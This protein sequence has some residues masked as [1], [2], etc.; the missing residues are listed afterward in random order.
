MMEK[1]DLR[2][3]AEAHRK[4]LVVPGHAAVL[5]EYAEALALTPGVVVA[6]YAAFRDEADPKALMLALAARGHGLALPVMVAKAQPLRFHAW[7]ETDALVEHPYGVREPHPDCPVVVP[8]VLLV[9]LLAFDAEGYRL[10][11]GGG[12][13]DRT[14]EALRAVRPVYAVGIAYAGQLRTDVPH[15]AHDQRLD[16]VLTENG[17]NR[18]GS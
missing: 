11:Y 4:T 2:R 7:C 6:G 13:Y 8:D 16:A 15:G 9:P 5:A 3:L 1:R 10:G 17:L 12:F 18:F 14:L